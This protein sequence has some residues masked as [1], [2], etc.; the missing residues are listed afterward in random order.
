MIETSAVSSTWNLEHIEQKQTELHSS[1]FKY[2]QHHYHQ[3]FHHRHRCHYHR[4]KIVSLSSTFLIQLFV[5]TTIMAS[6]SNPSIAMNILNDHIHAHETDGIRSAERMRSQSIDSPKIFLNENRPL[7]RDVSEKYRNIKIPFVPRPIATM[8]KFTVNHNQS[9]KYAPPS[10]PPPPSQFDPAISCICTNHKLKC[11]RL[12]SNEKKYTKKLHKR[13][14]FDRQKMPKLHLKSSTLI[15]GGSLSRNSNGTQSNQRRNHMFP[16]SSELSTIKFHEKIH[17]RTPN[18]LHENL[19]IPSNVYQMKNPNHVMHAKLFNATQSQSQSPSSTITFDP[20]RS[21]GKSAK[22]IYTSNKQMDTNKML[23]FIVNA[24]EVGVMNANSSKHNLNDRKRYK[25]DKTKRKIRSILPLQSDAS[26][27][28]QRNVNINGMTKGE[29]AHTNGTSRELI[30]STNGAS[31]LKN[32]TLTVSSK[33]INDLIKFHLV[34][35]F[36]PM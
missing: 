20:F 25:S 7:P 17:F 24:D 30:G 21:I 6:S 2:Y 27:L 22:N 15:F 33:Y 19:T 28:N 14:P 34:L 29:I 13:I 35:L 3:Q 32:N 9:M 5:A 31:H 26:T 16:S 36:T 23:L 8:T 11:M 1:D 10:M 18:E 12:C 4:V